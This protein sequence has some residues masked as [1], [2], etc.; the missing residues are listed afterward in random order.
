MGKICEFFD[1]KNVL[2]TGALGYCGKIL[3]E[4]L[5]RTCEG[6]GKIFI[7]VRQK[8]SG[9]RLSIINERRLTFDLINSFATR[10]LHLVHQSYSK[11]QFTIKLII[12]KRDLTIQ[13]FNGM[14]E[15]NSELLKK[16]IVISGDL[17]LDKMNL[18]EADEAT[19]I[20]EVNI[21]FHCA[22][23]VKF[24]E[25][26]KVAI[27]NNAIGTWRVLQLAEKM[28]KCEVF[29]YMST[30]F[31]KCFREDLDEQFYPSMH[32][33]WDVIQKTQQLDDVQLLDLEREL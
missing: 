30:A 9:K 8:K 29:S 12:V 25:P 18:S 14:R 10:P 27:N 4:K 17:G 6:I 1:K 33:V 20:N 23:N 2:V 7:I 19:L 22:G 13:V 3:V 11:F 5:L 31:S 24:D 28:R 15:S 21:V 16:I 32:D 26:L